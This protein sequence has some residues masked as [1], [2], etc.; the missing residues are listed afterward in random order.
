TR[1][2][3]SHCGSCNYVCPSYAHSSQSCPTGICVMSC[4]TGYSN[5][6]GSITNDCEA[7]LSSTSTCGACGGACFHGDELVS[8]I[9]GEY[10][11][12]IHLLS[13]DRVYSLNEQN[14]IIEDEVIMMVH[15]EPNATGYGEKHTY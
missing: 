4:D 5:C 10:K 11:E 12:A 3:T 7:D 2:T 6:D 15:K 8:M 14:Q 13:G 9:S 1:Y